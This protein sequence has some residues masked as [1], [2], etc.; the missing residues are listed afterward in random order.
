MKKKICI[1]LKFTRASASVQRVVIEA[2]LLRDGSHGAA[3]TALLTFIW[4]SGTPRC[5]HE[6]GMK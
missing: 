5:V 2:H 3:S 4:N 6:F 1:W